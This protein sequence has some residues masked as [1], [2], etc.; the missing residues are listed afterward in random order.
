MAIA[1]VSSTARVYR[2]ESR[3]NLADGAWSNVPGY[4]RV[5]C[6]SSFSTLVDINK[7]PRCFYRL[8]V[9]LP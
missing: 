9:S 8:N 3:T 6:D 4:E 7:A 1:F 2:L 5:T